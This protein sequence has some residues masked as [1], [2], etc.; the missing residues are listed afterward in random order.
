MRVMPLQIGLDE[1][2]GH[3]ACAAL[4]ETLT[5]EQAGRKALELDAKVVQTF[6]T[7][8][9]IHP[10][11]LRLEVHNISVDFARYNVWGLGFEV[12]GGAGRNLNPGI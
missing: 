6:R 4:P 9:V 7:N 11:T 10:K 8:A 1:V 2:R 12:L 3:G 5:H